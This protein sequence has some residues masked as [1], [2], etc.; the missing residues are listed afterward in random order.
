MGKIPVAPILRTGGGE[1]EK[2]IE[3]DFS[4]SGEVANPGFID[5]V[6]ILVDLRSYDVLLLELDCQLTSTNG[7]TA[8][9]KCGDADC[10]L[11]PKVQTALFR[12]VLLGDGSGTFFV[13]TGTNPSKAVTAGNPVRVGLWGQYI[14]A[15]ARGTIRLWGKRLL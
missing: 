12:S 9:L 2:Q 11:L 3:Q 5:S 6:S 8:A 10:L 4:F 15:S 1:W 7:L 14:T 13:M